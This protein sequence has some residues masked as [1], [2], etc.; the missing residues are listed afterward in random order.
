MAQTAGLTELEAD[1]SSSLQHN[2]LSLR[3]LDW[4]PCFDNPN[5]GAMLVDIQSRS[6]HCGP[7]D[8]LIHKLYPTSVPR[9][10]VPTRLG[11]TEVIRKIEGS[12]WRPTP[13]VLELNPDWPEYI[14]PGPENSIG[15]HALYLS[16]TYYRTHD[17]RRI[18]RRSSNGC[19][20]LY[21]E[22]IQEPYRLV[23]NGIEV[24]LI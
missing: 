23:D 22:H 10:E 2:I 16:W 11:R 1:V 4:Q 21:N 17:T 19:I 14:G 8:E 9:T 24:M 6:L 13:S 15:T 20:G 7:A 12:D 3:T 18:G 5:G